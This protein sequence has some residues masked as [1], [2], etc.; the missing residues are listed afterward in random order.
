MIVPL[1]FSALCLNVYVTFLAIM[2]IVALMKARPAC[3]SH[4]WAVSGCVSRLMR[5]GPRGEWRCS[6]RR[7]GQPPQRLPARPGSHFSQGD[8]GAETPP[9]RRH[10]GAGIKP[11]GRYDG[12]NDAHPLL[13]VA[14]KLMT[15]G[16]L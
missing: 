11:G 9:R 16:L 13:G 7:H 3:R 6:L 12:Y 8:T 14:T 4:I 5:D 2:W 10:A 15:Y 1:F